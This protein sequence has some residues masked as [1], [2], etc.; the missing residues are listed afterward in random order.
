MANI[1]YFFPMNPLRVNAGSVQRAQALLIYCRDKGHQVDFINSNDYWG[2]V[3]DPSDIETLQR[4]RLIRNHFSLSKKPKV[5]HIFD[6]LRY[7]IPRVILR[8]I[9][10]IGVTGIPDYATNF[11]RQL[12]RRILRENCYDY[13]IVSYAFWGNLIKNKAFTKQAKTIIDT[14]DFITAQEQHRKHF[15]LGKAFTDEIQRLNQFDE[16]WTV[17]V[18]E[19]YLFSQFCTNFVRLVP[20]SGSYHPTDPAT[21]KKFDLLYVGGD[22]PHNVRAIRWFFE[23]VYPKL[24]GSLRICMVGTIN[25]VLPQYSNV[26]NI[27]QTDD[28]SSY[29]QQS[30]IAIC[31][32]LSGTGTKVKVIEALSYGLPV[33]CSPKGVD[34]LVN[35]RENGC[36]IADDAMQF[37][38]FINRLIDDQKHYIV[39][40]EQALRYYQQ[41]HSVD[42]L[43]SVLDSALSAPISPQKS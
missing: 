33:V 19:Q 23:E 36:L 4:Q 12:F 5:T 26:V 34:G 41:Y 43:Y 3:I 15:R 10:K 37:A 27:P 1:L 25:N 11:S 40:S 42:Y 39:T 21:Q 13:I 30:R 6:F 28:L 8:K 22:N 35:K 29:Y 31:P 14:H 9:F 32:M 7:N 17:S 16:I 2:G 38:Y 24:P 18:D 20:I